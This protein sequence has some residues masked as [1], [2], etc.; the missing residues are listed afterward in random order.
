M[1]VV[2]VGP[3]SEKCNA[4]ATAADLAVISPHDLLNAP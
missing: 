3:A 2:L 1:K 4:N